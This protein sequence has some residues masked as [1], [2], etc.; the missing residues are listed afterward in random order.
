[1]AK[2]KT[3]YQPE[4]VEV[5]QEAPEAPLEDLVADEQANTY[6]AQDGDTWAVI[7]ARFNPGG[8]TNFEYAKHLVS[9]NGHRTNLSGFEVKL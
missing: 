2:K 3:T 7:A 5:S 4:P 6:I 1:M 9:V 8:M